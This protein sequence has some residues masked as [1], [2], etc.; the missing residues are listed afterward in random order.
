MERA[1]IGEPE[2]KKQK[3][4]EKAVATADALLD[5]LVEPTSCVPYLD[6]HAS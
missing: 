2:K 5:L 3:T 1:K 4:S 6:K